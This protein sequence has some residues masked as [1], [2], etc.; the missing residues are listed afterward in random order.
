MSGKKILPYVLSLSLLFFFVLLFQGAALAQWGGSRDWHMGP[1]MMGGWGMG[2]F[3]M[4]FMLVFWVLVIIGLI[5]L[6]KW[7][8]QTTRKGAETSNG[9]SRALDI[10]KERYAKGEIDKEEFEEKKRDLMG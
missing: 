1:G 9:G 3:G 7:L 4:I 8:V 10:L 5:F 2:W 6:I